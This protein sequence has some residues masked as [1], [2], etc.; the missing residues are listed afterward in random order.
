MVCLATAHPAKFGQAIQDA[1]GQDLAHHP[2]L[3]ALLR[4]PTRCVVLP[5]SDRAVRAYLETHIGA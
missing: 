3:D 1:L 5:A 4:L 2:A